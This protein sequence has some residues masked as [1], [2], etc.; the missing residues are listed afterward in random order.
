MLLSGGL[1]TKNSACFLK[2]SVKSYIDYVDELIVIDDGS[3]DGTLDIL[4]S[5]GSKVKIFRGNFERDKKRQRQEYVNRAK[6]R[7]IIC[8]DSDEVIY[9]KDMEWFIN[10][11]KDNDKLLTMGVRLTNYWKSFDKVIKNG[12]YDGIMQRMY[13]N[14]GKIGYHDLHHT[15]SWEP[16]TLLF[17]YAQEQ[18][19][20]IVNAFSVPHYSYLK[21]PKHIKDKIKYYMRRDNPNC[22]VGRIIHEN[23]V[24]KFANLHPFFSNRFD[25]P[26]YGSHGLYCCG[27]EKDK[28]HY[29]E[30]F[31]PEFHP[32]SIRETK[33]YKYWFKHKQLNFNLLGE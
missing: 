26:R 13:R 25:I 1:I 15:V 23:M 18:K 16:G 20:C 4:S 9:K 22:K 6:G 19:A 33:F 21:E 14:N 29:I 10:T 7:W 32:E 24:E 12:V 27:V 11:I 5:F 30:D 28:A 8:P 3:T 17:K 31:N 2:A